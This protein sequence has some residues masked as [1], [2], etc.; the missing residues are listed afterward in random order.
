[1][2]WLS[3]QVAIKQGEGAYRLAPL[4]EV[5]EKTELAVRDAE[6]YNLDRRALALNMFNDLA[7]AMRRLK[8][9]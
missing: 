8:A 1:L 9:V 4:A 7:S 2:D 3:T 6:R 5:W